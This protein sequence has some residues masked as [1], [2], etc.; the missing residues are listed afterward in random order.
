MSSCLDK[1]VH[2]LSCVSMYIREAFNGFI[3]VYFEGKHRLFIG[4]RETKGG[5]MHY[6]DPKADSCLHHHLAQVA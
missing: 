2:P 4:K 1:F 6:D 3:A 5:V